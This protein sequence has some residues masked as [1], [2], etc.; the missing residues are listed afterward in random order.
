MMQ[1]NFTLNGCQNGVLM[2]LAFSLLRWFPDKKVEDA[3][4]FIKE[5]SKFSLIAGHLYYRDQYKV[6]KQVACPEDYFSILRSAHV[7]SYGQHLARDHMVRMVKWQGYWWPNL[8]KY[9]TSYVREC[10]VCC[11]HDPLVHANLYHTMGVPRYARYI[12]VSLST[13]TTICE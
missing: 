12:Y 5:T 3:I 9:A 8:N 13:T 6:L 10:V 1:P 7:L 11:V 2:W 4:D